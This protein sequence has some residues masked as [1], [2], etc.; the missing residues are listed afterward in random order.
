MTTTEAAQVAA[1]VRGDLRSAA[2]LISRIEAH[3]PAAQAVLAALHAQHRQTPVFGLTGPPGAG[4]STL[5]DQLLAHLRRDGLR[6]AVLAVDPSSPFSG[7]AILGDRVRM[8]RHNTDSGV[9][10]RSMAARGS[11]GGLS[12]ATGDALTVLGAMGWDAIIVETVGV[13]QS[14]IDILRHADSVVILQTPVTGDVLQAVKAGLLEVGDI[15]VLNKVD[16]PGADR[17]LSG[18][19]E[20]IEFRAHAL[21]PD[22]WHT[23]L[24]K[25]QAV[26]GAGVDALLHALWA[27]QTHLEAHPDQ[28]LARRRQ[29]VRAQVADCVSELLRDNQQTLMN[30][31]GIGQLLDEVAQRRCAPMTAARRLLGAEPVEQPH[32]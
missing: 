11:L 5:V 17:A 9:F 2:R 23:P 21:P 32:G 14:E 15:F 22:A 8:A 27:H 7:G 24:L 28:A 3:D 13:G 4:K 1:V 12:R 25:T 6:V 26:D 31:P 16:A 10:I 19:R 30:N 29:Q 20:A 18:L